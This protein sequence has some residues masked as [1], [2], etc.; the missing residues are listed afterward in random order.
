MGL[1]SV[2]SNYATPMIN[3]SIRFKKK[4][5]SYIKSLETT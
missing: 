3:A 2:K 5:N 1:A 4:T